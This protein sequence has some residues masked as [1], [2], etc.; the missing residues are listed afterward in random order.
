MNPTQAT[1]AVVICLV[2]VLLVWRSGHRTRSRKAAQHLTRTTG[3]FGRGLLAAVLIVGGQWLV[4]EK[5][6]STTALLV[7]LGVPAVFA[8]LALARLLPTTTTVHPGRK[9]GRR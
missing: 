3:S 4:I 8:G 1:T 5:A 9:G 2:F 6:P 7:A